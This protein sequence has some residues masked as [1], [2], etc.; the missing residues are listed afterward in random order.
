MIDCDLSAM[1]GVMPRVINCECGLV[2]EG[3][4][5]DELLANA[6]RH[7]REQHPE[8]EGRI[9]RDDLLAMAETI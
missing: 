2:C 5:D 6:E 4:T 7:V 9:T 1:G 3:E 8:L